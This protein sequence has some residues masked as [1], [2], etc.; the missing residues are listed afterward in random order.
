M[1]SAKSSA[2]DALNE[3]LTGSRDGAQNYRDAADSVQRADIKA[4]LTAFA[5]ET[6]TQ[7]VEF[8]AE[9]RRL[10]GDPEAGGKFEAKARRALQ[11]VR[12]AVSGHDDTATLSEVE[13][14]LDQAERNYALAL[15]EP[16]AGETRAVVE[17]NWTIIARHHNQIAEWLRQDP[18][19]PS[20][21]P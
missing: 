18:G 5:N 10:G 13:S 15:R 6:A 19:N 3:L 20:A 11:N 17:R 12:S 7:A 2:I 8:E 14:G 21:E 9:I 4:A 16:L 1:S